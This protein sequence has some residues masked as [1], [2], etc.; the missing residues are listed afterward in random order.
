MDI[1]RSYS[2]LA[3][4]ISHLELIV[5]LFRNSMILFNYII[6]YFVFAIIVPSFH[7]K[8]HSQPLIK[9]P[10]LVIQCL[11]KMQ[12]MSEGGGIGVFKA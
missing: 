2:T 8:R 6:I 7:A 1:S 10:N 11:A 4:C 3:C 9:S 12:D 5:L